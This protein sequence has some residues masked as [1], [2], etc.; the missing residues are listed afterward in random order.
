MF[1]WILN[2][3]KKLALLSTDFQKV[4]LLYITKSNDF[5]PFSAT[6][7]FLYTL[8]ISENFW[9][10]NDFKGYKRDHWHKIG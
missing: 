5:N 3:T 9:F 6:G 4:R 10:G 1:D 8:K 2:A 7:L